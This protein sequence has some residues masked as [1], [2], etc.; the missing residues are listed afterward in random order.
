M[1]ILNKIY[2]WSVVILMIFV[3]LVV[4]QIVEKWL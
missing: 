4:P 1:K 2:D 3:L